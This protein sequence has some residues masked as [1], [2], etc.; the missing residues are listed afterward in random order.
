MAT[1]KQDVTLKHQ[2]NL[3]QEVEEIRFAA[4]EEVTVLKEWKDRV[5]VKNA[6][7]KHFNVD[8]ELVAL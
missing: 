3:S 5:L 6:E 1:I 8:K 2:S 4:G 7:G